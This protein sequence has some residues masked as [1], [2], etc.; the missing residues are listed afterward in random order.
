MSGSILK[1][2]HLTRIIPLTLLYLVLFLCFD[3][4]IN[5]P[6][7]MSNEESV[8]LQM[9]KATVL[10]ICPYNDARKGLKKNKGM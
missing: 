3:S 8:F 1:R 7:Q 4:V 5:L 10:L 2:N 9:C 6:S